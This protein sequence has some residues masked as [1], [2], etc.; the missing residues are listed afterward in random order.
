VTFS[1]FQKLDSQRKTYQV[2]VSSTEITQASCCN[3]SSANR[4][5]DFAASVETLSVP[6]CTGSPPAGLGNG[7]TDIGLMPC[8]SADIAMLMHYVEYIA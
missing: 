5:E 6:F 7:H 2:C 1:T 8:C 3:L 4:G